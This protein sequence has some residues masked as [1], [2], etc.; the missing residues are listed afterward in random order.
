MIN[1]CYSAAYVVDI[2]VQL[3]TLRASCLQRRWLLFLLGTLFAAVITRFFA[4]GF[5][6]G[7]P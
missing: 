2:F 7:T 6:L 5:F 1:I 4:L 3:S